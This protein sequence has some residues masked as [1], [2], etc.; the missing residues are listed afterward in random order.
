[1]L[2]K[3]QTEGKVSITHF[4]WRYFVLYLK[5]ALS[6]NNKRRKIMAFMTG[7]PNLQCSFAWIRNWKNQLVG[8]ISCADYHGKFKFPRIF[9]F[10]LHS[11]YQMTCTHYANMIKETGKKK[12]VTLRVTSHESFSFR[13]FQHTLHIH[14]YL[15]YLRPDVWGI[16]TDISCIGSSDSYGNENFRVIVTDSFLCEI[17]RFLLRF[18]VAYT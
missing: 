3:I 7:R 11:V 2:I 10:S 6:S 8:M 4:T 16:V 15:N 5:R 12:W 18:I 9:I 14:I 17:K 13:R 1:M